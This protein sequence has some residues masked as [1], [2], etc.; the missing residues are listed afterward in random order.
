MIWLGELATAVLHSPKVAS[1]ATMF[2]LIPCQKTLSGTFFHHL[3]HPLYSHKNHV[4]TFFP[5]HSCIT[6]FH[7]LLLS[8]LLSH[9]WL[10]HPHV[11]LIIQTTISIASSWWTP[12]LSHASITCFTF[13]IFALIHI[14]LSLTHLLFISLLPGC[15]AA[16]PPICLCD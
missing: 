15:A 11:D 7:M 13:T 1:T 3:Y 4:H 14:F 8:H 16:I 10:P 9:T 2:T 6:C 12:T 5:L